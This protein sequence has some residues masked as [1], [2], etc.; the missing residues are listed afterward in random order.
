MTPYDLA[1]VRGDLRQ[2]VYR[3]KLDGFSVTEGYHELNKATQCSK[4][5]ETHIAGLLEEVS[6]MHQQKN[7][8]DKMLSDAVEAINEFKARQYEAR[9]K[10]AAYVISQEPLRIA[11]FS[12]D[13]WA[14]KKCFTTE[15]LS[16]DHIV[17][18]RRGGGNEHDNL[19]TLCVSC[20]SSKGARP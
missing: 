12:R 18:V 19:Q 20:N 7:K 8:M 4:S 15:N 11:I 6:A 1:K 14:C 3:S 16:I 5:I 2:V 9:R 13:G 10:V 17:P